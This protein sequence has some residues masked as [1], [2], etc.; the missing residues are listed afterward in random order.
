M[1][2]WLTKFPEI[3][4]FVPGQ[5]AGMPASDENFF[6][7][8]MS[9]KPKPEKSPRSLDSLFSPVKSHIVTCTGV[10]H[11][12]PPQWLDIFKTPLNKLL[13]DTY[14]WWFHPSAAHYFIISYSSVTFSFLGLYFTTTTGLYIGS[15]VTMIV[16]YIVLE[17]EC[18]S[19]FTKP[20]P[21]KIILIVL[22]HALFAFLVGSV[23]RKF[24]WSTIN[25][26]INKSNYNS[27]YN[28][29]I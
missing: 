28:N 10:G 7:S 1:Q 14:F 20:F 18:C 22:L 16:L 19:K 24:C 5:H 13:S 2:G 8:R 15:F 17:F 27:F 11:I 3:H 21:A 26:K 9:V 23:S 4:I 12:D 25:Q 29:Y 6:P